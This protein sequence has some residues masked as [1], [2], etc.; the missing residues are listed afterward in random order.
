MSPNIRK[1]PA[2]TKRWNNINSMLIQVL[3]LNQCLIDVVSRLYAHWVYFLIF[4]LNKLKSPC[5]SKQS[6]QSLHCQH[7]ETL[8]PWL[9]KMHPVKILFRL[10]K[11][12]GWSV[13][14]LWAHI[15]HFLTLWLILF[16]GQCLTLVMLNKL[17]C[18]THFQFSP[19]QIT[20]SGCWYTFTYWMTNSADPDQLASSEANWSGSTLFAKAGYIRVKQDKG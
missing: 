17:R 8:H 1:Y 16:L 2:G 15:R 6:Y 7:E 19:N 5:T 4:A 3:M 9:S 10:H 14:S 11:C 13:S 12:A 18:H 20:W